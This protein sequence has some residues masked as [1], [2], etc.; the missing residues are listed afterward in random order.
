LRRRCLLLPSGTHQVP[1]DHRKMPSIRYWGPGG[2]GIGGAKVRQCSACKAGSST[3]RVRVVLTATWARRGLLVRPRKSHVPAWLLACHSPLARR[4][5]AAG[6]SVLR[7]GF[8]VPGVQVV[9]HGKGRG[10]GLACRRHAWAC[11]PQSLAGGGSPEMPGA[12]CL[13]RALRRRNGSGVGELPVP[14]LHTC[15]GS[16]GTRC[17]S[18]G[19]LLGRNPAR[20]PGR[21]NQE[22]KG[23]RRRGGIQTGRRR[24]PRGRR[25][26]RGGEASDARGCARAAAEAGAAT[27]RLFALQAGNLPPRCPPTHPPKRGAWRPTPGLAPP[28]HCSGSL[29]AG[30]GGGAAAR[31][32]SSRRAAIALSSHHDSAASHACKHSATRAEWPSSRETIKS[33]ARAPGPVR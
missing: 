4:L 6:L 7:E 32:R 24:Q 26:R 21:L 3:Y 13:A 8:I 10:V 9:K 23:G 1:T 28:R 33:S 17:G 30:G 25:R 31:Q 27:G 20:P 29:P 18:R 15:A 16:R 5:T 19:P 22:V 14:E 2:R 11:S 12:L